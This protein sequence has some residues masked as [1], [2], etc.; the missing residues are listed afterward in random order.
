MISQPAQSIYEPLETLMLALGRESKK[1]EREREGGDSEEDR[2]IRKVEKVEK[3]DMEFLNQ[4]NRFMKLWST[5]ILAVGRESKK[6]E[7]VQER[8]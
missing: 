8:R 5:L 6:R 1:R 7:S 3:K 2:E 4:L